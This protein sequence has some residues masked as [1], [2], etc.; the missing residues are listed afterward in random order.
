MTGGT[1]APAMPG[2]VRVFPLCHKLSTGERPVIGHSGRPRARPGR[3]VRAHGQGTA[4][5]RVRGQHTRAEAGAVQ[6]GVTPFGHGPPAAV[7]TAAASVAPATP[8]SELGTSGGGAG[9]FSASRH[10]GITRSRQ[11][12]QPPHRRCGGC[13]AVEL[14]S[15]WLATGGEG[16]AHRWP[17]C[18][19]RPPGR[20]TGQTLSVRSCPPVPGGPG[21]GPG[22]VPNRDR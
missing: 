14:V 16:P 7:G 3:V 8:A 4:A 6:A 15:R 20:T 19:A 11:R 13:A 17:A 2:V 12:A 5:Q 21:C 18:P 1:Q 10:D 9:A 22:P